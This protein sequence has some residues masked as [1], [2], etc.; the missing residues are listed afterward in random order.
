MTPSI[1]ELELRSSVN[2]CLVYVLSKLL[3]CLTY[4]EKYD[5]LGF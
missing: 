5:L 3:W 4:Q 2:K 1:F